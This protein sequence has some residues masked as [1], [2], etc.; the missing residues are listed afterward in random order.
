MLCQ[1]L[2]ESKEQMTSLIG[3][4]EACIQRVYTGQVKIAQIP[5]NSWFVKRGLILG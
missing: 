5:A 1:L 3:Q 4:C 2:S